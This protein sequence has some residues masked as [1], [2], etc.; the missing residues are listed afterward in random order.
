MLTL[1][2][3]IKSVIS[4]TQTDKQPDNKKSHPGVDRSKVGQEHGNHAQT[5]FKRILAWFPEKKKR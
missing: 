1:S 5:I 4:Y 3:E 2:L